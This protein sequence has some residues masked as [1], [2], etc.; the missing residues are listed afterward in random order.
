MSFRISL[1]AFLAVVVVLSGARAEAASDE[2]YGYPFVDP[3]E[4]TVIGTP[5]RPA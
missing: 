1:G 4:A 2:P 5:S 3:F